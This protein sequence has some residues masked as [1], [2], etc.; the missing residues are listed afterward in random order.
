MV[1][2]KIKKI[3]YCRA[4]L[5]SYLKMIYLLSYLKTMYLR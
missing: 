5:L 3:I 2:C 1:Y 4:C